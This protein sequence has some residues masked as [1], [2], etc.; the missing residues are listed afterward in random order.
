ML[1]YHD[2]KKPII[3][4][5]L[6]F[7]SRNDKSESNL[8]KQPKFI[9][10]L[11]QLMALF[12]FCPSCKSE[13]PLV[14][15]EKVGTMAKIKIICGND[16]CQQRHN[17]WNSQPYWENTKIPAGNLLLSFAILLAGGLPSK[18]LHMLKIMGVSCIT[19]PTFFRHQRV[20]N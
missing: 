13:N 1:H 19:L 8:R 12:K 14:E 2:R 11:T 16:H 15:L 10:F 7:L 18:I 5:K 20:C 3:H 6:F 17:S 9:V 4:R